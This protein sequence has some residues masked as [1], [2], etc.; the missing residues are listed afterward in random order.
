VCDLPDWVINT[1]VTFAAAGATIYATVWGVMKNIRADNEREA[2]NRRAY[3][4]RLVE[5]M[6][7]ELDVLSKFCYENQNLRFVFIEAVIETT[8]IEE[9][10]P[11]QIKLF[12]NPE[13]LR[14][15]YSL[16]VTIQRIKFSI[17]YLRT[18]PFGQEQGI[19]QTIKNNLDRAPLVGQFSL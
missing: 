7:R 12:D 16:R 10:V 18:I 5:L 13:L 1:I 8:A 14:R 4:D 11:D 15:L 3:K 17:G 6:I 19:S 9:T 2:N